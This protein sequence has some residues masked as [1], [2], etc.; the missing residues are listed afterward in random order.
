M[1]RP[2]LLAVF[3][4]LLGVVT[5]G[6]AQE[7][8]LQDRVPAD[9]LATVRPLLEGARRDSL[10]VGALE[11]KVL[12]GVAKG[13]D[14]ARIGAAVRTLAQELRTA[15]VLLRTALPEA[16]LADGEVSSAALAIRQGVAGERLVTLWEHRP[17]SGSLEIPLA[18]TGELARR[19]IDPDAAV[20]LMGHI[21]ETGTP[22]GRA[23]QIPNR[24]D[25]H[26]PGAGA[27]QAALL[28]A[29]RSL[30]IPDPPGRGPPGGPPVG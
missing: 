12:E 21:L 17:P 18:V 7:S 25:L 24:L 2:V 5:P 15:R 14:A 30:G 3:G 28:E 29:L 9:V 8:A 6:A 23:A 11:S 10:P 13:V 16:P 4:V 1:R 27:P 20:D 22:L 26:L 19:G